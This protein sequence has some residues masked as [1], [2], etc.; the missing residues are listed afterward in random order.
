MEAQASL[1]MKNMNEG[2][3]DKRFL[4]AVVGV[5]WGKTGGFQMQIKI[6]TAT[7]YYQWLFMEYLEYFGLH[8]PS[9]PLT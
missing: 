9:D 4:G 5:R 7:M 6:G 1:L 2:H 8:F 3:S